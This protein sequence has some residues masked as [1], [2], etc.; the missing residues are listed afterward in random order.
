[1]S[2][3]FVLKS[4]LFE[5]RDAHEDDHQAVADLQKNVYGGCDYV[6]GIFKSWIEKELTHNCLVVTSEDQV[7]GF[8]SYSF[9]KLNDVKIYVLQGR[10]TFFKTLFLISI[11]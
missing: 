7:V 6:P 11:K 8:F 2:K 10:F 5:I 9:Y 3:N 1:M 4:K